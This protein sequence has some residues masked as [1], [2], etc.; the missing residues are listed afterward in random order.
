MSDNIT[1]D[2]DRTGDS[3]SEDTPP[4]PTVPPVGAR[5]EDRDAGD[6]LLVVGHTSA[7][8]EE[9]TIDGDD[10]TVADVNPDHGRRDPVAQ[11]VYVEDAEGC[12]DIKEAKRYAF[13]V[14]RLQIPLSADSEIPDTRRN[15]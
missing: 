14:G 9:Y 8:A 4:D 11:C 10:T 2:S 1:P 13:P 3:T 12:H 7:V 6:L 15:F 5:V